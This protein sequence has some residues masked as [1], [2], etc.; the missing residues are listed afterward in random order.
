MG[1]PRRV[2]ITGIG[3]VTPLGTSTLSTW[4][5]LIAGH[6]AISPITA[7]D[8]SKLP[9]RIA[10]TVAIDELPVSPALL[11]P[12][13]LYARFALCAAGEALRDADL[14]DVALDERAGVSIGVGMSGLDDAILAHEQISAG[15]HRRVSPFTVPRVLANTP[16]S[17]VSLAYSLRGPCVAAST[18]CAAGLHA[19]GEAFH[20]VRRGDADV[21][22]AGGAEAATN[23][24]AVAAFSRAR[25]LIIDAN[26]DAG[27]A[28]RPF[29]R[30]R[31]GFVLAE[32]AAVL[33]LESE[34]HA[35]E[36]G[37]RGVYAELRSASATAD[38]FH[39]T[40]P[41]PKGS[42]ARR[43]MRL[44]LKRAEVEA[45]EVDY[46][47]AH[48]TSTKVGDAVERSAIANVLC[49]NDKA[50]VSSTKGATG[51]LLGAAGAMEAAFTALAISTSCVPPTVNLE[52]L[53]EDEE[54]E[55][56]GWGDVQRYVPGKSVRRQVDVALCNSFGFGG[57][58][59][60]VALT[61]PPDGFKRRAIGKELV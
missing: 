52:V 4:H 23:A 41:C 20:V 18:A 40:A 10:G 11:A 6:V 44:A 51:H 37:V 21:M 53:D 49:D 27:M 50:V 43:A 7:W 60:C 17:L 42:G 47:N 28:S 24:V 35:R 38:A 13:P 61:Q 9:A 1:A 30:S 39:L 22:L 14:I 25:A 2:L 16:A 48:A 15:R 8:A 5:R 58:N 54:C 26:D 46:V 59:A 55:K 36:R 57:T 45:G 32:G 29:D 31:N 12:T 56:M 33:V 19:I 3:L 34:E